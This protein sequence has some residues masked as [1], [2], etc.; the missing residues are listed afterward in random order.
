MKGVILRVP[1]EELSRRRRTGIDRYDEMWEG[2]L[3][4]APAPAYEHQRLVSAIDRSLGPLC[5][6]S[7]RGVLAPGINV[8]SDAI[9]TSDYRIPDLTFVAAG[10]QHIMA[11]D[12]I[13]GGGPD[14]VIEVRSPDDESYEK[15]PFF[16]RLGV[17]E[18]IIVHRDSKEV[19]LYRLE[20]SEYTQAGRNEEGWLE[21]EV[22]EVRF[23]TSDSNLVI[24][25]CREPASQ[26]QI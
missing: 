2:V 10:R 7:G 18:V 23:T 4:M 19:E 9:T 16:A 21:S 24:R 3:H 14:A 12:G 6:R 17:R 20:G 1:D 13:R 5:E 25:D 22:F 11:A 15:F 8:F 26:V